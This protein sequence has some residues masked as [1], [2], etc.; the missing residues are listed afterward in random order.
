MDNIY[1]VY[2]AQVQK[3]TAYLFHRL[4]LNGT[5]LIGK[6]PYKQEEDWLCAGEKRRHKDTLLIPLTI[7]ASLQTA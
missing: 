3:F 5:N 7:S 6:I 2:R 1:P 4:F